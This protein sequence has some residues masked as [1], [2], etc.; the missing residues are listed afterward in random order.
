MLSDR[1]IPPV[2]SETA[3]RLPIPLF[4]GLKTYARQ[5]AT[6]QV[7]LHA[8]FK[9]GIDKSYAEEHRDPAHNL[10]GF[11][12]QALHLTIKEADGWI[13]DL[14][15]PPRVTEG[16]IKT[17]ILSMAERAEREQQAPLD[18]IEDFRRYNTA[19]WSVVNE[20]A[21]NHNF[22]HPEKA[23][24][25]FMAAFMCGSLEQAVWNSRLKLM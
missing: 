3:E 10:L 16:G 14:T 25:E 4:S 24:S 17:Y 20:E 19:L 15:T 11:V 6:E 8:F 12:Y 13:S 21:A 5:F 23:S 2:S 22:S 7:S 18:I 1:L 9:H